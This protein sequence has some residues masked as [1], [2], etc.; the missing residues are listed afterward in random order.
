[1]ANRTAREQISRIVSAAGFA[2]LVGLL[3]L[4]MFLIGF[5]LEAS[6]FVWVAIVAIFGLVG[7]CLYDI[8][9]DEKSK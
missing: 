7:Y 1:M 2:L 4:T 3:L 6:G 5:A 9:R 8:L